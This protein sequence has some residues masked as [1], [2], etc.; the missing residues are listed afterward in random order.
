MTKLL[1]TYA[2]ALTACLLS[3]SAYADRTTI[4]ITGSVRAP[5]CSAVT[6]NNGHPVSFGDVD[7]RNLISDGF[8][9]GI[10]FDITLVN[11]SLHTYQ[12]AVFKFSANTVSSS[13]GYQIAVVDTV[14]HAKGI[15]ITVKD[16]QGRNIR[17]NNQ[18]T[19][20][21][22]LT[23]GNNKLNFEAFLVSTGNNWD[24]LTPGLIEAQATFT[25]SYI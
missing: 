8:T 19:F 11:C 25:V 22:P 17:F 15:A 6:V 14:N 2:I 7:R 1:S 13:S 3:T 10:P 12:N 16:S 9:T 21:Y 5:T 4:N 18:E 23:N 20:Q 24:T